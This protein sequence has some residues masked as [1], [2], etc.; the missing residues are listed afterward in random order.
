[1]RQVDQTDAIAGALAG[2]E[3]GTV[4][5]NFSPCNICLER[6]APQL[7]SYPERYFTDFQRAQPAIVEGLVIPLMAGDRAIETIWIASHDETRQ[8][9]LED[10]RIMTSLADFTVRLPLTPTPASIDPG[11]QPSESASNL[12]GAQILVVDN[13]VD[14][15]EVAAFMLEQA[16]ATV[17]PASSALEALTLLSESPPDMLLS[18][19][20]MPDM[21]GYMLM[22]QVR[23]RPPEQGGQIPAIALTAYAGDINDQQAIAAGFQ[24]HLA[25][26][27]DP[28]KLVRTIVDLLEQNPQS[29]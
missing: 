23:S 22:Q 17:I 19:I 21:D 5:K 15:L 27:I 29:I 6:Q 1:L 9:D 13:D 20:G 3:G 4:P 14:A 10:V 11:S 24:Q 25:K 7:Y 12:K 8:F 28:E 18:D 26:P 2:Y 16:G